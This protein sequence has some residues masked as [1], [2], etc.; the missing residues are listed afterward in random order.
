MGEF[1]LEGMPLEPK[2]NV[3]IIV[4][5]DIDANGILK[6]SGKSQDNANVVKELKVSAFTTN[7]GADRLVALT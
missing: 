6:I 5:F 2:G 1:E 7:L 4:K 3:K